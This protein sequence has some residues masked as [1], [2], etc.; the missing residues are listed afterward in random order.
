M[1]M[2]TIA[3]DEEMKLL[4]TSLG[5]LLRGGEII[6]LI[7]D[8]GTGKT[9]LTKGIGQGLG[10]NED[11]Q[12]P[13]FTI[14]RVY[15][16]RDNMTLYHYDFYRLDDAGVMAYEFEESATDT[17]GVTVVEWAE[18]VSQVL[19]ES[20]CQVTISYDQKSD[21]RHVSINCDDSHQYLSEVER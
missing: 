4:G 21:D 20:R 13:S 16:A 3:S 17:K 14:S 6:E 19:P 18:S 1:H 11:I 9:T 12:S 10:I 2:I 5:R 15:K 7:G 8:V